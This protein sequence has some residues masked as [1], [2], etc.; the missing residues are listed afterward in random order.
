VITSIIIPTV[1]GREKSLA[2]TVDAYIATT[3]P[4]KYEIIIVRH[5]PTCG[6]AWNIGADCSH[7]D[8]IHFT[9]DDIVPSP[10]WNESAIEAAEDGVIPAP[11]VKSPSV[12]N[13]ASFGHTGDGGLMSLDTPDRTRCNVS[14]IPFFRSD[15]WEK[16]GP[17]LPIHYYSDD[18]LSFRARSAGVPVETRRGYEFTHWFEGGGARTNMGDRIQTDRALYIQGVSDHEGSLVV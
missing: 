9:A 1:R 11:Y 10:G 12:P 8:Y 14:V 5:Q 13:Q 18:Y 16:I 3:P 2:R 17:I 15:L 6:L 7:S 4:R